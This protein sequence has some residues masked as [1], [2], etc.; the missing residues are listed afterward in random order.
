MTEIKTESQCEIYMKK[1]TSISTPSPDLE[2]SVNGWQPP[3]A[4]LCSWTSHF[5]AAW[6]LLYYS[7]PKLHSSHMLIKLL[8]EGSTMW[9]A[10]DNVGTRGSSL[11]SQS[12]L[13]T[14]VMINK[15]NALE[16]DQQGAWENHAR[17]WSTVMREGGWA[18]PPHGQSLS[19]P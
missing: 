9:G 16:W 13:Q 2:R 7:S 14:Y 19:G 1:H 8:Y 11:L 5:L 6:A 3:R 18:P 12:F 4:V 10:G 17:Q 15:L